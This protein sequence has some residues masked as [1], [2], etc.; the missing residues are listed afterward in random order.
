[1]QQFSKDTWQS[2]GM[3]ENESEIVNARLFRFEVKFRQ[4]HGPWQ[5]E[6]LGF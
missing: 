2:S 3:F 5:G 6:D 1:M 4:G